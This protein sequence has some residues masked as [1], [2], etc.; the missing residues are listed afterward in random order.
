MNRLAPFSL[1]LSFAIFFC[2]GFSTKAK[3][4]FLLEPYAGI[5]FNGGWSASGSDSVNQFTGTMFGARAGIQKLGFMLGVDGR[6]GSWSVDNVANSE[7]DY[8][9]VALFL[10]YDFPL[11]LRFYAEFVIGGTVSDQDNNEFMKPSGFVVGAGYKFFPYLSANLEYATVKYQEMEASTGVNFEDRE[12]EGGYFL[13]SLSA[14]INIG[15]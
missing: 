2:L 13:L 3:A 11:L 5:N 8:Q 1:A 14:P 12:D 9:H 15:L 6:K 4:S 7:L 10:G